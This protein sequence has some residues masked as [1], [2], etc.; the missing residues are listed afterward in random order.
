S[1][2]ILAEV[3]GKVSYVDFVEGESIRTDTDASGN[4]RITIV[5][6]KGDLHPQIQLEDASGKPLDFYYLPERANVEVANGDQIGAGKVLAKTP[7]EMGGTQDITSGL[8]RVTELFEARNPKDP[9]IISE[10]DGEVDILK[11]KKRGKRVIVIK[12]PQ[13][14]IEKEHIIPHGKHLRV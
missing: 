4:R 11:E 12:S 1:V 13:D 7:R 9:A 10:I 6:H 14:G 3:G 5:E 8:P 2:P